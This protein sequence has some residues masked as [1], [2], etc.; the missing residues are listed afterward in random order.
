[1][2]PNPIGS[3]IEIHSAGDLN[4]TLEQAKWL[5]EKAAAENAAAENA[6]YTLLEEEPLDWSTN[7]ADYYRK[8]GNTYTS[9]GDLYTTAPDF[10]ANTYYKLATS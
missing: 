8:I 2:L 5:D 6:K 3:K 9:L 1:M 10:A 4:A 7:F